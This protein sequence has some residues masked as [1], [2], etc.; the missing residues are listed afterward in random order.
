MIAA[1]THV[2]GSAR[3]QTVDRAVHPR[4]H[5][6]LEAF[7]RRTGVPVLLN[8][9]LNRRGEPIVNTPEEAVDLFNGTEVDVLVLEDLLVVDSR[10]APRTEAPAEARA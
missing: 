10:V 4:F 8:T 5:A 2:D 3:V 7:G 6:L 1:V 9:S